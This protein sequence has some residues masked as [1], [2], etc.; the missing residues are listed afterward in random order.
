MRVGR[1]AVRTVRG[2]YSGDETV[3]VF[4]K[5][6]DV[7]RKDFGVN[8]LLY[9][10]LVCRVAPLTAARGVADSLWARHHDD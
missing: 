1:G 2:A 9:D 7:N 5:G 8:E 10:V 4:S 6:C 3:R